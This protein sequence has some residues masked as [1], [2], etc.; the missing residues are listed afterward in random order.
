MSTRPRYFL[1]IG[2][3]ECRV[4]RRRTRRRYPFRRRNECRRG[5]S[6]IRTVAEC[7]GRQSGTGHQIHAQRHEE[8][9][10]ASQLVRESAEDER[11]DDFADQ[12]RPKRCRRTPRA[13]MWSVLFFSKMSA[14]SAAKAISSPFE[15]PRHSECDHH[16]VC[17]MPTTSIGQVVCRNECLDGLRLGDFGVSAH[18]SRQL[19]ERCGPLSLELP[20][21]LTCQ[22]RCNL[23]D[24]TVL[25]MILSRILGRYLKEE[26]AEYTLK[27]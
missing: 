20:P 5:M 16:W 23:D 24:R 19:S 7:C 3:V 9:L 27:F 1:G 26:N 18:G 11:P 2:L 15:H 13:D 14:T 21:F 4:R 8:E 10:A 6:P 12:V 22:R 25:S 17:G